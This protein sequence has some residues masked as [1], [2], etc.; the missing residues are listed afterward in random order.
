MT[1]IPRTL[2]KCFFFPTSNLFGY[3]SAI[4][5]YICCLTT[6]T[7]KINKWKIKIFSCIFPS[8]RFLV[9]FPDPLDW[10]MSPLFMLAVFCRKLEWSSNSSSW[11]MK[12]FPNLRNYDKNQTNMHV[13]MPQ[14]GMSNERVA[15]KLK[16]LKKRIKK[17]RARPFRPDPCS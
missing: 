2:T 13:K 6:E 4:G 5:F 3:V 8:S 10:M 12:K 17:I 9:L 15:L 16:M 7:K 14:L 1:W 11:I